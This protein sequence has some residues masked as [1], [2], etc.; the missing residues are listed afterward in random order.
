MPGLTFFADAFLGSLLGAGLVNL[1]LKILEKYFDKFIDDQKRRS[2][3]KNNLGTELLK[4]CNEASSKGYSVR[5]RDIEH[6]FFVSSR[7]E[8][9]DAELHKSFNDFLSSWQLIASE[10]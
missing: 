6:I 4:I 2:S 8:S 1:L 7:I 9:L 5:P 3:N 10:K